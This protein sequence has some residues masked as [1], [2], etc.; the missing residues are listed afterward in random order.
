MTMNYLMVKN[1]ENII[2]KKIVHAKKFSTRLKGLMFIDK[3]EGFEG[4]LIEPCNSI[5]T[6]F[7]KFPIDVIF[8]DRENKIV[9]IKRNMKPWRMTWIIAK[10]YKVL[11]L[12][13]GSLPMSIDKD[14][15][16]EICTS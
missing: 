13:G 15:K 4:M 10:A 3:M 7:M 14:D 8:L 16:L 6:F 5:H 1:L 11:E 12:P 9:S 2:S